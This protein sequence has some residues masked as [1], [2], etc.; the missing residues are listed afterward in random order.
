MKTGRFL[1]QDDATKRDWNAYF[2]AL[3]KLTWPRIPVPAVPAN[4]LR[5]HDAPLMQ[6]AFSPDDRFLVSQDQAGTVLIWDTATWRVIKRLEKFVPPASF[7]PLA[8]SPGGEFITKADV[9]HSAKTGAL[10]ASVPG[11]AYR[12]KFSPDGKLLGAGQAELSLKARE[13]TLRLWDTATWKEV[14]RDK[15]ELVK[16]VSGSPAVITDFW[17]SKDSRVLLTY[18]NEL[19]VH[20]M[21]TRDFKTLF[22]K[23]GARYPALTTYPPGHP[24]ILGDHVLCYWTNYRGR[25]CIEFYELGKGPFVRPMPFGNG[26]R[27]WGIRL[28]YGGLPRIV[29]LMDTVVG[30]LFEGTTPPISIRQKFETSPRMTAVCHSGMILATAKGYEI[31]VFALANDADLRKLRKA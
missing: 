10:I 5:E 24:P 22:H 2:D 8:L 29:L 18:R 21:D 23:T 12:A 28:Q 27:L 9:V 19:T 16:G 4:S 31:K 25:E 1:T 30:A 26:L 14:W 7:A 3:E 13:Q 20:V 6:I 11:L 15:P 17:F